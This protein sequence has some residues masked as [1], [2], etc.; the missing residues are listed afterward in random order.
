MTVIR[1][2]GDISLT[3]RPTQKA[4]EMIVGLPP[5]IDGNSR[6]LIVGTLP[7]KDSLRLREYYAHQGNQIW[8]ILGAVYSEAVEAQYAQRIEF[9]RRHKL[10]LWDVLHSGERIGSSDSK[11]KNE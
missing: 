3:R 4:A 2:K 7:G 6:I 5:V 9:L 10:G 1:G 11:I 8:K